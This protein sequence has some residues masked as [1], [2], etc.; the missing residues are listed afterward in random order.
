MYIW[1]IK[2][3]NTDRLLLYKYSLGGVSFKMQGTM[4]KRSRTLGHT[5]KVSLP[6]GFWDQQR[7]KPDAWVMAQQC[8]SRN[9]LEACAV[10]ETTPTELFIHWT[11]SSKGPLSNSVVPFGRRE[12]NR[13]DTK[14][15]KRENPCSRESAPNR[16]WKGINSGKPGSPLTIPCKATGLWSKSKV[17]T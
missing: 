2:S 17:S 13:A 3:E 11:N 1:L 7:Q 6:C 8:C 16:Q 10:P 4:M 15:R 14:S 5:N 9:Q 12:T